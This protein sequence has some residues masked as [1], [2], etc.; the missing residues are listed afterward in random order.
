M[1]L[2]SIFTAKRAFRGDETVMANEMD[3]AFEAFRKSYPSYDSTRKLDELRAAEY[4]RLDRRRQGYFVHPAGGLYP[5]ATTP[6]SCGPAGPPRFWDPPFQK[7][8]PPGQTSL[9]CV[10]RVSRTN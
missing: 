5:R 3:V 7:I 2:P 1:R 9:G 6:P 8:S 4:A 10:A